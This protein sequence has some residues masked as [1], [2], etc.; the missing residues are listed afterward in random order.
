MYAV[1]CGGVGG[2][3]RACVGGG[4]GEEVVVLG[5]VLCICVLSVWVCIIVLLN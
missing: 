2:C 3:V 4:F 1:V 5:C